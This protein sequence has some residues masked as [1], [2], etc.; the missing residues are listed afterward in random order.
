MGLGDMLK[1]KKAA[2]DIVSDPA[3]KVAL[4]TLIQETSKELDSARKNPHLT[5]KSLKEAFNTAAKLVPIGQEFVNSKKIPKMKL[6]G[7][8]NEIESMSERFERA[9]NE[10]DPLVTGFLDSLQKNTKVQDAI[11]VVASKNERIFRLEAD[12]KGGGSL[13][14]DLIPGQPLA[15]PIPPEHFAQAEDLV[16]KAKAKKQPPKPGV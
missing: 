9:Y 16:A 7:M 5:S 4:T 8:R 11:V 1:A 10:K 3:T 2:E 6:F 12:G 14:L 15:L 13:K